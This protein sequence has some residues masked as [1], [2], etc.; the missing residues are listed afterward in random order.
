MDSERVNVNGVERLVSTVLGG[1]LLVRS[2]NRRSVAGT[3]V[4]LPLLYRGL[5]GHSYLT[6]AVWG[7]GGVGLMAAQSALLMGAG[8]VIS[9]DR[10]P[11]RLRMAR[12]R[13]GAETINYAD[14]DGVFKHK[15]DGC[16]RA[17][18]TP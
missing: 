9:I 5:R 6:V 17:V 18:F 1:A 10:F 3:A 4:A 7:C 12:E 16:V 2:L 8:R 15:Q 14:G 13:V 11:E